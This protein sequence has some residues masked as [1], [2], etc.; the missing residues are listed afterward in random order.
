[1]SVFG[2]VKL[3]VSRAV[4]NGVGHKPKWHEYLNWHNS[5]Q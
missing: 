1:M 5:P 2:N 3:R 4:C